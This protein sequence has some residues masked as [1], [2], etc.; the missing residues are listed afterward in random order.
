M[1]IMEKTG[2]KTLWISNIGQY[3][4][5]TPS[6]KFWYNM[7][8][9]T[10]VNFKDSF[11]GKYADKGMQIDS[12]IPRVIKELYR[13]NKI[14]HKRSFMFIKLA[15]LHGG[16]IIPPEEIKNKY[17]GLSKNDQ[18]LIYYGQNLEQ[19][20]SVLTSFPET[21]AI[22]Y[23]SD[24]SD[25]ADEKKPVTMYIYLSPGLQRENPGLKQSL[26]DI[27]SNRFM[28]TGIYNLFLKIMNIKIKP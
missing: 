1:D 8:D 4:H 22:I 20:M 26:K 27:A 12:E 18:G 10:M 21:K 3:S 25:N 24:H 6:L 7:S 16:E 9:Y 17:P 5:A 28:T 13:T 15:G 2:Y 11:N 19:I 23:S 14:D